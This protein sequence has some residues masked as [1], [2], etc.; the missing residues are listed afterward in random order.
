MADNSG[1]L[2]KPTGPYTVGFVDYEWKPKPTKRVP[3]LPVNY[4]T[5]RIYYPSSLDQETAS[6]QRSLWVVSESEFLGTK[7]SCS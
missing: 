1:K 3:K 4:A 5:V 2:P 7:L 6:K